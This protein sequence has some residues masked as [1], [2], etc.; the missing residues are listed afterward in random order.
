M[1][2]FNITRRETDFCGRKLIVETGKMAK[3]ANG[4]VFIQYGETAVL[5]VKF[6]KTIKQGTLFTTFHHAASKVNYIFGDEADEL[7]MTAK[8]KS[9]RVE[10]EPIFI[11]KEEK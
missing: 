2:N 1:H 10:I 6:V 8:F 3:Q 11:D 7:I 4:S 9:V 5:P